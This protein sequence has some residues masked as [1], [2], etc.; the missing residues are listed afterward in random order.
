[1]LD[2]ITP[3]LL[4]Y[5]EAPNIRRTL[6]KLSWAKRIVVVDSFSK[7]ETLDIL[8]EHHQ[9]DLFQR[10]FDTHAKQWNYGLQQIKTEWILSLDADYI[11]S[12]QLI[13]EIHGLSPHLSINGYRA[14]FKYCVFGKPIRSSVLPQ[15]I[16]LFRT[17]QGYYIDDGH[18]QLLKLDGHTTQL[19][20]CIYHDDRKPISRWLWAQDRYMIMEA[21][22]LLEIP[23][24]KLSAADNLRRT[25]WLSPL[26]IL[27]YCLVLK[28]GILDGWRGL[29]YAYQRMLAELILS[30]RLAELDALHTN[31]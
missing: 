2:I 26:V 25:K 30:I 13:G 1:M 29:Y 3:L 8:S 11:L 23:N 6:Q 18:T 14:R 12:N 24:T 20:G 4:T 28:G 27:V 21:Q 5:D 9:V 22:K 17:S 10:E 16:V 7:D 19:S 15:R 31:K